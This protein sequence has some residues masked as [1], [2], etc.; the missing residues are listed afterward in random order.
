MHY[1][2]ESPHKNRN[3]RLGLCVSDCVC[4]CP[5]PKMMADEQDELL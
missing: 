5:P 2:N 3:T 4:V 1:A